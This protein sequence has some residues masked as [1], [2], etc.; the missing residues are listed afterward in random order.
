MRIKQ[1]E[2]IEASLGL[3]FAIFKYSIVNSGLSGRGVAGTHF[4]SADEHQIFVPEI[5]RDN[6]NDLHKAATDEAHGEDHDGSENK[7]AVAAHPAPEKFRHNHYKN[8]PQHRSVNRTQP[9]DNDNQTNF[10]NLIQAANAGFDQTEIVVLKSARHPG[11]GTTEGKTENLP[12][13]GF[14]PHAFSGINIV[15]NRKKVKAPA[16]VVQDG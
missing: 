8:R 15:T 12:E 14:N 6:L 1:F 5:R 16:R 2:N 7:K 10:A 13:P 11:P 3:G 4:I 9:P